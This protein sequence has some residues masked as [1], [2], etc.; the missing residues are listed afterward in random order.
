V[1]EDGRDAKARVLDLALAPAEL[2]PTT[3]TRRAHPRI[4]IADRD[5]ARAPPLAVRDDGR[6]AQALAL[7]LALAPAE[8]EPTWEAL[9]SLRDGLD[10]VFLLAPAAQLDG[11]NLVQIF[12]RQNADPALT[13]AVRDHVEYRLGRPFFGKGIDEFWA[14]FD[15][16]ASYTKPEYAARHG[17]N[18]PD[19]YSPFISA[20]R[21]QQPQQRQQQRPLATMDATTALLVDEA[22]A[23]SVLGARRVEYETTTNL[24]Q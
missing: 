21:Q 20:D 18:V 3:I 2:K 23:A 17:I 7:A 8:L 14:F 5:R 16:F 6:D 11:S 1:R 24:S 12:L 15:L 22:A 4:G 9:L 10:T 13:G 19:A